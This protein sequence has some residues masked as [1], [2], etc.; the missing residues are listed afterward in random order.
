MHGE[1]GFKG[2]AR[3]LVDG[4]K[5]RGEG[6]GTM[7]EGCQ[8]SQAGP[9]DGLRPDNVSEPEGCIFQVQGHQL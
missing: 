3:P 4:G 8:G 2:G 6:L 9:K 7:G 5:G 1:T